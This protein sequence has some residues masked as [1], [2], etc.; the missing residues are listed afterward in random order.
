MPKNLI[1]FLFLDVK[2]KVPKISSEFFFLFANLL[3]LVLRAPKMSRIKNTDIF[4]YDG[5]QDEIPE[6]YQ[7]C[8]TNEQGQECVEYDPYTFTPNISDYDLNLFA[9]GEHWHIY[10]ILG[11]HQHI[12]DGIEG[13]RFSVWAPNAQRVSVITNQNRWDGRRHPMCNLGHSGIWSLFLPS[14]VKGELYKYE[15]LSRDSNQLLVKNRSL[16]SRIRT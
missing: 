12:I 8:W 13:I 16:C 4:E 1:R 14:M 6:H 11:S 7:I 10:R 3:L 9:Q 2:R 15:I 5:P